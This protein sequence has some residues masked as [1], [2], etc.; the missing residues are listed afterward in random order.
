VGSGVSKELE[1][2]KVSIFEIRGIM[3]MA[4]IIIIRRIMIHH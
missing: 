2:I 4:R 1:G 3:G